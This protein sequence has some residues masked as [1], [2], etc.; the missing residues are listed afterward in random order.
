MPHFGK[1]DTSRV[2]ARKGKWGRP[3]A[4]CPS[5][6]SVLSDDGLPKTR[7]DAPFGLLWPTPVRQAMNLS[8]GAMNDLHL[9]LYSNQPPPQTHTRP[10]PPLPTRLRHHQGTSR[11]ASP[12]GGG[13]GVGA[14][15]G[16]LRRD[17]SD[18]HVGHASSSSASTPNAPSPLNPNNPS[19][20]DEL[21]AGVAAGLKRDARGRPA[22]RSFPGSRVPSPHV[23]HVA[24]AYAH[25]FAAAEAAGEEK[26]AKKVRVGAR[27]SI[28]CIT[29]RSVSQTPCP[30]ASDG[31][32][33][34][35]G[36][37]RERGPRACEPGQGTTRGTTKL[38]LAS[39]ETANA[40]SGAAQTGL[41]ASSARPGASRAPTRVTPPSTEVP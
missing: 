39:C 31:G 23:P 14:G 29:C 40:R 17:A 30:C 2:Q 12:D 5:V 20:T 26:P 35:C 32:P 21:T 15:A 34:P 37:W 1:S 6:A 19:P 13:G 3:R 11:P 7:W 18:Y 28:A 38:T 10:L 36:A 22:E 4:R 27:A 8:P 25:A 24:D 9:G 16:Q 33:E 41:R